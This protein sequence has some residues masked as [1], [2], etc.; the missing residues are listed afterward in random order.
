MRRIE[1]SNV[2]KV[3]EEYRQARR[4]QILDAARRCFLRH[5]FDGTSMQDL[6]AEAGLSS[7]AVYGYFPSKQDMIVAIVEEN[8]A[9]VMS[10]LQEPGELER[11]RT[12]AEMLGH[13]TSVIKRRHQE[14][15]F[16]SIALLV[17][18]EATRN[19]ELRTRLSALLG[20]YRDCFAEL[21]T[22]TGLVS[23]TASADALGMLFTSI[24][25]GCILHF[26][27]EG[28]QAI[29]GIESTVSALLNA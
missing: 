7:G 1:F 8:I 25:A 4:V 21:A 28:E 13:I 19:P 3:S 15:G 12:V 26:V 23:P 9:D 24:V 2:P 14:N 20:E 29:D 10:A 6:L 27:I 5:G 11:S 22:T 17:W 18:S 16:A